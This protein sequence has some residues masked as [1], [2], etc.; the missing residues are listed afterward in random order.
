M[1]G[2]LTKAAVFHGAEGL[3]VEEVERPKPDV[4]EV[5]VRVAACGICRTDLHYLHGVPTFQKPPLILGHEI[6]GVVEGPADEP[7]Q[8]Q[9]VLLPPVIPCGH[10]EYCQAGRGTLCRRMVMLGNHRDG[11]FAENVTIPASAAFPLP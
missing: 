1:E 2:S 3:R 7:L 8:G 10:C 6:S 11:G 5:L 4:G 9:R